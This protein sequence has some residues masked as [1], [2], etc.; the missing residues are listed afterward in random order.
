M[1]LLTTT[2]R[3]VLKTSLPVLSTKAVRFGH[4]VGQIGSNAKNTGLFLIGFQYIFTYITFGT[5]LTHFGA[6]PTIPDYW[7][8]TEAG[9]QIWPG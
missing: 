8:L 3:Q 9:A 4:K 5:N 7:S 6:K 2:V 1:E